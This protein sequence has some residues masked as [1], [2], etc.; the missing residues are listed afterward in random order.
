MRRAESARSLH[1]GRGYPAARSA[2]E[3]VL[4]PRA[5]RALATAAERVLVYLLLGGIAF[6]FLLPLLWMLNTAFKPQALVYA[7]PPRWFSG[8]LTFE[9]FRVGW[10]ALPFGRFLINTMFVTVV[11]VFGTLLS[12]TLVGFGFAR[13][14]GRGSRLLFLI[15]L[16]TMMIPAT[17]TLI[18][19]FVLF[20]RIGWVNSYLPI[21]VPTFLGSPFFIF[22]FRQYFRS[23]PREYFDAAEIDGCS[24]FMLYWRIAI[25]MARPALVTAA[26][27]ATI[28]AWNDFLDP[29][30]FLSTMDKFTLQLGL[31]TFHGEFYT[32]LHLLMPMALVGVAP[33]LILVLIG[34]RWILSGLMHQVEK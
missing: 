3:F 11:S 23:I 10:N 8:E 19:R 25:P 20:A 7:F 14:S 27:F 21:L 16:A 26:L 33:V 30:V 13:Y 17:T 1:S 9:N 31:A 22:L 4:N 34:Q 24:P 29:L 32:Q 28:G 5:R 18:P 12:S 6:L 2:F 15:M